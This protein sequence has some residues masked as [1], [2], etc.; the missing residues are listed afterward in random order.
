MGGGTTNRSAKTYLEYS[1]WV[2]DTANMYQYGGLYIHALA[3]KYTLFNGND[4][5]VNFRYSFIQI[6]R[7]NGRGD[8]EKI[9]YFMPHINSTGTNA[10]TD[11][12]IYTDSTAMPYSN[13]RT[14]APV[15][16]SLGSNPNT[17]SVNSSN[18]LCESNSNGINIGRTASGEYN[19]FS[20][21]IVDNTFDFYMNGNHLGTRSGDNYKSFVIGHCYGGNSV[22]ARNLYSSIEYI[23][24]TD[25][26][27]TDVPRPPYILDEKDNEVYGYKK[28]V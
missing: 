23:T 7:Y 14:P 3:F 16:A 15:F 21:H 2:V 11:E 22:N 17:L 5:W 27:S 8:G 12:Y 28:E 24:L 19:N 20:V 9:G 6:I 25:Q 13:G 4:I 26:M 10:I 1:P 18:A